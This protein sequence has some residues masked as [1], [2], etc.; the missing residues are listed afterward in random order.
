MRW[1]GIACTAAWWLLVSTAVAAAVVRLRSR[2]AGPTDAFLLTGVLAQSLPFVLF[3]GHN[4]YHAPLVPFLT[5]W[6]SWLLA[7]AQQG[8]AQ[9]PTRQ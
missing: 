8:Q 6:A 1:F 5:A 9:S 2:V 4:R 7:G 3:D